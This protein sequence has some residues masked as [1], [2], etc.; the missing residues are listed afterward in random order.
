MGKKSTD[1]AFPPRWINAY[2]HEELG[3]YDDIGV[4]APSYTNQ[5]QGSISPI[6][7]TSPTNVEELYNNILQTFTVGEPLMIIYDRLITYRPSTFYPHKREQLVYYLYSTNLANVNNA[8][9]VIAD[10]LDREDD[11]AQDINAWMNSTNLVMPPS[12]WTDPAIPEYYPKNVKFWNTKVYVAQ[13]SRDLIDFAS[14]RTM[15]INK[16]IIEYDYNFKP[17][18]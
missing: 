9:T 8:Y 12:L 16:L 2:V 1:L 7:A 14:A 15:Y 6:L 10:L 11:S 18:C 5:Y 13:E 4:A 3:K 17:N